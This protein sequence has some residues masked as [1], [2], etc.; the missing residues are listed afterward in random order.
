MIEVRLARRFPAERPSDLAVLFQFKGDRRPRGI[1]DRELTGRLARLSRADSFQGADGE[2]FL[3]HGEHPAARRWL[4]LGLGERHEWS[5]E[6]IRRACTRAVLRARKLGVRRVSLPLLEAATAADGADAVVERMAAAVSVAALRFDKYRSKPDHAD[7]PRRIS[8]C[9]GEGAPSTLQRA[10]ERGLIE[11]RAVALARDLVNEPGGALPPAELAA[12]ARKIAGGSGL[13]CRIIDERGLRRRGMGAILGVGGGSNQPPCLIHLTHRPRGRVRRRVALVG[14]GITFDSGGL[15]LKPA[16][17]MEDMKSDKAGAAAVLGVMSVLP[18]LDVPLEVHGVVAAAE[19][20]PS[21]TA[22]RPGDVVRTCS[23]QT[24]E[25]LNTDAE[26]RLVLADALIYAA[27]L[28]VEQMV[29]VATLTGAVMIALGTLVFGV[30]GNCPELVE[31]LKR[32]AA[33]TGEKAWELPLIAEYREQLKSNVADVR[34]TGDRFGGAI[35]AALFLEHF[36]DRK[37]AWAHLDVAGPAFMGKGR[38]DMPKGA[39]GTPV[40]TLLRYLELTAED[41]RGTS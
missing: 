16:S 31:R 41:A 32:A 30:M 14:K 25:V 27:R 35:T 7:A 28:G 24:V 4:V 6:R 37:I 23:G 1:E 34:N 40:P 20:M 21:G 9:L 33:S 5:T 3:W 11:A 19:N 12:R 17:S 22:L 15:S 29:D 26:G 39:S 13:Q 10:L 8:L 38:T 2:E 18:E 36:V